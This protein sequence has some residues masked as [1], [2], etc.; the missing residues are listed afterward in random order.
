MTNQR[1]ETIDSL[2]GMLVFGMI[3]SHVAGLVSRHTDLSVKVVWLLTALV[4][5]S[6]FMFSFGYV[7]QL[8]YFSKDRV[9]VAPRMLMTA[10]KPLIAFYI[11]GI[12]WRAF[13]DQNLSLKGVLKILVLRD[14]PPF[15]EFLVSF[16][17]V[18]LVSLLLFHWIDTVT[19]KP[20]LFWSAFG[21]LLLMTFLPY[22]QIHLKPLVLFV[23]TT[24]F[25]T[26][27]VLQYLPIF[28]LGAYFAKHQ[29][30]RDRITQ[31][32]SIVGLVAFVVVYS[33]NRQLPSRFPPSALWILASLS[34]VYLYY[35]LAQTITRW[36]RVS[37]ILSGWGKNVLFY[38][39]ISNIL[40]FTFR[41]A[42]DPLDLNLLASLGLTLLMLVT[43]RFFT[44]IVVPQPTAIAPSRNQIR[45]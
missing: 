34:G 4:T 44:T 17:L 21:L 35:L 28:L 15:S 11:S 13:V 2:K 37:T 38:L 36:P 19:A 27:P 41:G 5:F 3:L 23:G 14:I 45:T 32:L 8:A 9:K 1:D 42:Y 25:P 10:L 33:L 29:L 24:D 12:Y 40:I 26:F 22:D 20:S 39:L 6:G 30:Q 18:I 31:I 7:C 43:I 16:S